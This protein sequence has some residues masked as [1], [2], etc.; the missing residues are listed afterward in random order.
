MTR[1]ERRRTCFTASGMS[2]CAIS[3]VLLQ[4]ST[5]VALIA[6]I[7]GLASGSESGSY[8]DTY[9]E[10]PVTVTVQLE[11]TSLLI[12]EPVRMTVTVD[13]PGG[14]SVTF[15]DQTERIGDFELVDVEQWNAIPVESESDRRRW[16]RSLRLETLTTGEHQ[17]PEFAIGYRLAADSASGRIAVAPI[18]VAVSSVLAETEATDIT[19][20]REIK[21]TVEEDTKVTSRSQV[22]PWLISLLVIIVLTCS[23]R[24]WRRRRTRLPI[25]RWAKQEI[26]S[27]RR[28]GGRADNASPQLHAELMSVL[29]Q[30][31]SERLS[32]DARSMS[33]SEIVR[34]L[35]SNDQFPAQTV[36][37]LR[38]M[39]ASADAARFAGGGG[40]DIDRSCDL[41][42]DFVTQTRH[43]ISRRQ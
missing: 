20:F 29:R 16:T 9:T 13:A 37:S 14:S 23:Y 12:A 31:V 5:W 35:E 24:A 40:V 1:L 39:L 30:Y 34:E 2:T 28:R 18:D 43:P 26:S 27:I 10:G 4:A 41:L 6:L 42:R 22:L 8:E 36:A 25:D 21:G 7:V 19:R 11:K 32:V 3:V 15:P 38:P 33:T 17:I